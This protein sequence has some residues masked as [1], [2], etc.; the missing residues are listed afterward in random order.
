[1]DTECEPAH[2]EVRFEPTIT[3]AGQYRF[4]VELD[5]VRSSCDVD[6]RPDGGFSGVAACNHLLL[7]GGIARD[8]ATEIAGYSL[9]RASD[10][11]VAV[12]RGGQPWATHSFEPRYRSV[13]LNGEGCGECIV[14]TESV[15]LP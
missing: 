5:G 14:A 10:V 15:E 13:E 6:F 9:A 12:F 8:R 3:Q 7:R 11:S 2:I 4:D 1:M